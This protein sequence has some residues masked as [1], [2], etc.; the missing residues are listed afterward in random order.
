MS[1]DR[2]FRALS[3]VAQSGN[4]SV[5]AYPAVALRVRRILANPNYQLSEVAEAAS[6]DPALAAILLKVANSALYARKGP[7]ITQLAG[8]VNRIGARSVSSIVLAASVG[9]GAT[10]PGPLLDIKHRVWQR[11]LYSALLCQALAP[12]RSLDVN[13]AF[14][15]GLLHGFGRSVGATC[16]E[17]LFKTHQ[18]DRPYTVEQW[19]DAIEPHRAQLA[20]LVAKSW[21]L[22]EPI[23]E[24]LGV[25]ESEATPLAALVDSADRLADALTRGRDV[26]ERPIQFGLA[27]AE[28]STLEQ[29]VPELAE[30]ADAMVSE[31]RA[32]AATSSAI[33]K[34]QNCLQGELKSCSFEVFDL[35]KN[36]PAKL[37][38]TAIAEDGLVVEGPTIFPE[39][40]VVRLAIIQR[41]GLN[42]WFSVLLSVPYGHV[43][44]AEL[45]PF[46]ASREFRDRWQHLWRSVSA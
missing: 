4:F 29:I 12:R 14:L 8:A 9:T 41:D 13:D 45:Q 38:A 15:A 43:S 34:P 21:D 2:L 6:A 5:P 39:G 44:R 37:I 19:L 26:L 27:P 3:S 23:A 24:A 35:R 46:A 30:A 7:P 18:P 17:Q 32:V 40:T 11:S 22:P 10:T 36:A 28:Q 20:Q 33:A 16:L 31:R 42:S 1:N 25:V